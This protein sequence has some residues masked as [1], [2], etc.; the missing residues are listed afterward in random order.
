M[1]CPQLVGAFTLSA[2][3]GTGKLPGVTTMGW[4]GNRVVQGTSEYP[5]QVM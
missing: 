2:D 1:G 4:E 3:D 5:S